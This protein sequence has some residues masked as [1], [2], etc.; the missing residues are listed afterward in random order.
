MEQR[1]SRSMMLLQKA[2]LRTTQSQYG[3]QKITDT[4]K[5]GQTS[6]LA[7]KTTFASEDFIKS[8]CAKHNLTYRIEG[9]YYYLT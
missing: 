7:V 3:E 1:P 6:S 2:K 4:F 9:E 8:F 5:A